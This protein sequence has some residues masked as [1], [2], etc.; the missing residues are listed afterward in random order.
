MKV[1]ANDAAMFQGEYEATVQYDN[2]RVL[3]WPGNANFT[4][5]L[6]RTLDGWKVTIGNW[7][8]GSSQVIQ[9]G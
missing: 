5:L 8:N 3:H 1:L 2:G 9:E 7:G 6:E 4:G